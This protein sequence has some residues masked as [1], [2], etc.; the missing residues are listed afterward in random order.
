MG[1]IATDCCAESG[2]SD[3][4][5]VVWTSTDGRSW[6]IASTGDTFE[7]ASLSGLVTDEE[8]LILTGTHTEPGLNPR[9]AVWVSTDGLAWQRAPGDEVPSVVAAHPDG[10]FI[11][12]VIGHALSNGSPFST[13]HDSADGL[14]WSPISENWVGEVLDVAVTPDGRAL[15][16]GHIPPVMPM[17]DDPRTSEGVA[18]VSDDGRSWPRPIRIASATITS[19]AFG[20]AGFLAAGMLEPLEPDALV[21]ATDSVWTSVDGT[22]WERVDDLA[23]DGALVRSVFSVGAAY[24][25][26]GEATSGGPPEARIWVSPDAIEWTA[27]VAAEALS[28]LDTVI[29]DVIPTDEGLLAVGR[30]WDSEADRLVPIAWLADR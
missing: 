20:N 10:R 12:P 22:S 16:V 6:E 26:V 1:T 17:P 15:A 7:R 11:G 4:A 5:G 2:L 3:S 29:T 13:F 19:V 28:G 24:I 25:A 30:R 23:D 27:V 14:T 9:A 21:Q 18:Y 8:R